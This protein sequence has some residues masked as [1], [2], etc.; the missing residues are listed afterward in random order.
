MREILF[1]GV[2]E[3]SGEWMYGMPCLLGYG[4]A[5]FDC[6]LPSID[7]FRKYF[8]F[9]VIPESITE[10]TGLTDETG[11]K[12]F[13]GDVV[14]YSGQS[15]ETAMEDGRWVLRRRTKG[16]A[17]TIGLY[18]IARHNER[19]RIIGDIFLGVQS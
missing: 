10:Y 6:I 13:E 1:R 17:L 7:E 12:L 14:L 4:R 9:S 15:W 3:D 16:D 2:H 19:F 11:R 18:G 5:D 8:S